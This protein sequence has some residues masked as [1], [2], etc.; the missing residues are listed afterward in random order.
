MR[1]L[2]IVVLITLIA[3]VTTPVPLLAEEPAHSCSKGEKSCCK[4]KAE[5]CKTTDAQ[6]CKAGEAC[7]NDAKC[8]TTATDGTHTCAMKHADGTDCAGSSCCKDKSCETK[9][10]S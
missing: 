6:C 5:S 3:L 9:K 2:S 7:C 8:C 10:T 4:E 1:S